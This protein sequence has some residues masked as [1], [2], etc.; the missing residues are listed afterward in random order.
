MEPKR[1]LDQ[2]KRPVSTGG[3]WYNPKWA[4]WAEQTIDQLRVL[5][6]SDHESKEDFIN[7]VNKIL[8]NGK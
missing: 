7:R 2:F 1:Y 3:T 8:N 5:V 6:T 4:N